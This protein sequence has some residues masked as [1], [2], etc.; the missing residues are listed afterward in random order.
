MLPLYES[1]NGLRTKEALRP[2]GKSARTSS[3]RLKFRLPAMVSVLA[4]LLISLPSEVA[5]GQGGPQFSGGFPRGGQPGRRD[6]AETQAYTAA[7][8]E[9]NLNARI[10]AI[11]QFLVTY[12]QSTLRQPAIA[13]LLEAQ[14][15]SRG[16]AGA[17][18]PMNHL[19]VAVPTAPAAVA[20]TEAPATEAPGATRDSLLQQPP[21]HA[22]ITIEPHTLAIKADNSA[23]SEILHAIASSTGMKLD[24]FTKDER[25][26]GSYGP[27]ETH[28]VLL[29]LLQGSGY[30]V[31]MVGNVD[32]GRAPREL[33]LSQ[34][35]ASATPATSAPTAN[36]AEDDAEDEQEVQQAPPETPLPGRPNLG[37]PPGASEGQQP[38]S[39]QQI[40]Q[41]LQRQRQQD[42]NQQQPPPQ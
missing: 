17:P 19:P 40:L 38:R 20:A 30:N 4:L 9:P 6:P 35:T 24:G 23:L 42:P 11:Q 25:I 21:K 36:N 14:K 41:D 31:V 2:L 32:D 22:E 3:F 28:E 13:Q 16:G 7:V 39:P 29:S 33:S 10:S 27:G 34:R 5:W 15:E 12:P 26:F 8:S 1:S 37:N 18:A